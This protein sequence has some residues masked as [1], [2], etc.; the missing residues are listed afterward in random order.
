MARH[1]EH[2]NELLR[3][4]EVRYENML[5]PPVQTRGYEITRELA[6]ERFALD[7]IHRH[8]YIS[9]ILCYLNRV[10]STTFGRK[11]AIPSA[12]RTRCKRSCDRC[13]RS[14]RVEVASGTDVIGV[15]DLADVLGSRVYVV[16]AQHAAPHDLPLHTEVDLQR[17]RAER[18]EG[19]P[20]T[21]MMFSVGI[22]AE[23]LPPQTVVSLN[24]EPVAS[25]AE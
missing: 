2:V 17:R 10:L 21:L 15:D 3:A 24:S 25:L 19:M 7:S 23:L 4:F 18:G 6:A 11:T 14:S 12:I 9:F 1:I 20:L 16:H 13:L 8:R 5:R 22:C